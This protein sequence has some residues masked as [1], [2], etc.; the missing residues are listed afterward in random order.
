MNAET[1]MDEAIRQDADY[2]E[3]E[4]IYIDAVRSGNAV[5]ADTAMRE[6]DEVYRIVARRL[7]MQREEEL[8]DGG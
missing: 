2:V 8:R 4:R 5:L 7:A 3:C 6:R 1:R